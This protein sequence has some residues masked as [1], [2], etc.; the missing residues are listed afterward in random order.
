[1]VHQIVAGAGESGRAPCRGCSVGAGFMRASGLRALSIDCAPGR[2]VVGW[3]CKL[4]WGRWIIILWWCTGGGAVGYSLPQTLISARGDNYCAL[5]EWG[6][7]CSFSNWA[8]M[9]GRGNLC[10]AIH[11]RGIF[12]HG[13]GILKRGRVVKRGEP[14][15]G[16]GQRIVHHLPGRER[17]VGRVGSSFAMAGKRDGREGSSC[18]FPFPSPGP[19][20]GGVQKKKREGAQ[21]HFNYP[22]PGAQILF[23]PFFM[24][25]AH[26]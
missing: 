22:T 23:S 5:V 21:S 8:R 6:R 19:R 12:L 4:A 16:P 2:G 11:G 24:V 7:G 20:V 26:E 9:D 1:M 14:F 10:R 13:A 17:I 25:E 3:L 18:T 15:E